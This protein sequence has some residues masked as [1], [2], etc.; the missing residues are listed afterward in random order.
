[1]YIQPKKK[2]RSRPGRVIL[3]LALI[4]LGVYALLWRRDEWLQP[5]HLGPT[6]APTPSAQD[7]MLEAEV[8]YR[9]G[10]LNGAIEVYAH[11][12]EIDPTNPEPLAQQAR[13]LTFRRRT[14]E[15]VEV[16]RKAVERDEESAVARAALCMA[17]DWHAE[18]DD[19]LYQEA[20]EECLAAVDLDPSYTEAHAYLA[21][22]YADLGHWSR[23][24]EEGQLAV[25]LD[26]SSVDA[27]RN[28]AYALERQGKYRQA[29]EEYTRAIQLHP[30]LAVL[31]I[32]AGRNYAYLNKHNDAIAQYERA[33]VIDPDAADAWDYLGWAYVM[34]GDRD[35]AIVVLEKAIEADPNYAPAYGHLGLAYYMQQDYEDAIPAFKKALE[36]GDTKPEYYYEIGLAYVFLDQ[37]KDA[38]PWLLQALEIDPYSGPALEGLSRCP[39][40]K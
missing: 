23:A 29:I 21:E 34:R 2:R 8:L 35:R 4:G 32:A 31:Y 38:R 27:H 24:L 16:A 13:L 39:E 30:R 20:L 14:A 36:L 5:I 33:T 7:L 1:M 15:A 17:L 11:I 10:E 28:L 26:D 12:A 37:C 18:A 40:G 22:V 3:M 6:P 25:S 19:R 9:D